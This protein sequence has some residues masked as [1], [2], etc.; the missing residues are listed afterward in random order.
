MEELELKEQEFRKELEDLEFEISILEEQED[1]KEVEFELMKLNDKRDSLI[2]K[3]HI[4]QDAQD[5]LNGI[6]V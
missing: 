6:G 2:R 5:I 1:K 4:L 3:I